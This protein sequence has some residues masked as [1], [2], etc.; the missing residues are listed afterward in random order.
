M[1][2]SAAVLFVVALLTGGLAL[3]MLAAGVTL[4]CIGNLRRHGVRLLGAGLA[5]A[6]AGVALAALLEILLHTG[7]AFAIMAA[8]LAA[9]GFAAGAIAMAVLMGGHYLLRQPARWVDLH[10]RRHG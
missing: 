8:F 2:L 5:G 1:F 6:V 4:C 7:E 10:H 9:G 3:V